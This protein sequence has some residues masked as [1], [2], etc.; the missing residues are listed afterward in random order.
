MTSRNS[1]YKILLFL[2]SLYVLIKQIRFNIISKYSSCRL[3]DILT[4]GH[5]QLFPSAFSLYAK[6]IAC[7]T[8]ASYL[9]DV[10]QMWSRTTEVFTSINC[11][12]LH[13]GIVIRKFLLHFYGIMWWIN[14]H[15][16][17]NKMSDSKRSA[18]AVT[19]S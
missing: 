14:F 6:L 4:F 1:H 16:H 19:I 17:T 15:T 3:L 8:L 13:C 11:N 10:G 7:W 2:H 18:R 12:A 5:F 9:T